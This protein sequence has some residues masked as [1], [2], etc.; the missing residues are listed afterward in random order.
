LS[1]KIPGTFP[2]LKV[3]EGYVKPITSERL[4]LAVDTDQMWKGEADIAKIAGCCEKFFEWGYKELI[5]KR[6]RTVLWGGVCMLKLRQAVIDAENEEMTKR[7]FDKLAIGTASGDYFQDMGHLPVSKSGRDEQYRGENQLFARITRSRE[8]AST[9]GL[10]EYRVEVNPAQLVRSAESGIIG[11]RLPLQ[12]DLALDADEDEN[13]GDEGEGGSKEKKPRK[14]PPHP[15]E[16]MLLWLPAVMLELAEP[17]LVKEFEGTKDAKA[18][19]EQEAAQRKKG[20]AEGKVVPWQPKAK[21]AD[22]NME[23]ECPKTPTKR[24]ASTASKKKGGQSQAG[25]IAGAFKVTK[26]KPAAEADKGK[27]KNKSF[28]PSSDHEDF[29]EGGEG[30]TPTKLFTS[31]ATAAPKPTATRSMFEE[32]LGDAFASS[33]PEV[34]HQPKS[35]D[36]A[37]KNPLESI[38]APSTDNSGGKAKPAVVG[39]SKSK[40]QAHNPPPAAT[41]T[42]NERARFLFTQTPDYFSPSP[43]LADDDEEDLLDPYAKLAPIPLM[44][45]NKRTTSASTKASGSGSSRSNSTGSASSG[46]PMR[47]PTIDHDEVESFED[48]F[49]DSTPVATSN[50]P[51]PHTKGQEGTMSNGKRFHFVLPDSPT[52]GAGPESHA[53]SK[54]K[55]KRKERARPSSS[56]SATATAEDTDEGKEGG[57]RGFSRKSYALDSPR[58]GGRVELPH[59]GAGDVL[60]PPTRKVKGKFE[61]ID[62][63]DLSDSD[64]K[65]APVLVRTLV[66]PT[67]KP[68]PKA[69]TEL[70][71][72]NVKGVSSGKVKIVDMNVIDLDSD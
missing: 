62:L 50:R 27:G 38:P 34:V 14:P 48:V 47:W 60:A 18:I 61:V 63:I 30:L 4:R 42:A 1:K 64:G 71:I 67:I 54:L 66:K 16:P 51:K 49:A 8:H 33:L 2:D 22:A 24:K 56:R 23:E 15:E 12:D 65:D 32:V 57:V 43:S 10:L 72:E 17:G 11:S 5:V 52:P 26:K 37:D 44:P 28:T 39:P 20:R 55:G 40:P 70:R 41:R 45:V 3:L 46:L 25:A 31:I 19:K 53:L 6:F 69:V 59:L 58:A 29:E 21:K 35:F 9:D 7:K 36:S 13:E 68:R